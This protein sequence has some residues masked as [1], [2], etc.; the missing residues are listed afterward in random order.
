MRLPYD[1]SPR[2]ATKSLWVGRFPF[3]LAGR[4]IPP[5]NLQGVG[6]RCKSC[7]CELRHR[8]SVRRT[9]VRVRHKRPNRLT[10]RTGVRLRHSGANCLTHRAGLRLPVRF[11]ASPSSTTVGQLGS[12]GRPLRIAG[13]S[14]ASSPQM[15]RFARLSN[16]RPAV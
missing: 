2:L 5:S 16:S 7:L 14:D 11:H 15:T 8:T 9:G 13:L 6:D 1:A 3:G 4:V 10:L 12:P